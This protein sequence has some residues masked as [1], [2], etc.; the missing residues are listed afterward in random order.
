MSLTFSSF[1]FQFFLLT[2][3]PI[4]YLWLQQGWG[5]AATKSKLAI[6]ASKEQSKN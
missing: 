6:P 5:K 1:V 4:I 3:A 2:M